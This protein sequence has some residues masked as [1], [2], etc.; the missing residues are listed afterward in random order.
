MGPQGPQV[1]PFVGIAA[2]NKVEEED[3]QLK[4]GRPPVIP[5]PDFSWSQDSQPP[6]LYTQHGV[7]Q[8]ALGA[9]P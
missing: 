5:L 1:S 6:P 7:A 4:L 8:S 2:A 9:N 3:V